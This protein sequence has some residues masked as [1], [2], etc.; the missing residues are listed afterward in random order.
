MQISKFVIVHFSQLSSYFRFL[1]PRYSLS[2]LLG[3][4]TGNRKIFPREPSRNIRL[5]AQASALAE[6]SFNILLLQEYVSLKRRESLS[7]IRTRRPKFNSLRRRVQIC[8]FP[9]VTDPVS[10]LASLPGSEVAGAWCWSEYS[11]KRRRYFFLIKCTIN[12]RPH[13]AVQWSA[14]FWRSVDYLG[15]ATLWLP[16]SF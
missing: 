2:P 11:F 9:H 6:K 4:L 7:P 12:I 3:K 8:F 10:V 15:L 13:T 14:L 5:R 1:K 16:K